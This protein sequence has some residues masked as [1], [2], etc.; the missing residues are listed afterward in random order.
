MLR[1]RTLLTPSLAP[2]AACALAA[3]A[4]ALA[5]AACGGSLHPAEE[6]SKATTV[7]APP[8]PSTK[9]LYIY[10]GLPEHGPERADALQIEQGI[11]Y[12]LDRA[13]HRVGGYRVV[14]TS[15]DDSARQA[16]R[17]RHGKAKAATSDGWNP[18]AAA[19]AAEEAAANP[20]TVAYIGDL[21]SG[22]TE[23]SLPILNE[24]GIAQ[25]TPGSGYPG[26]TVGVRGV[27]SSAEPGV[28]YP[29]NKRSMVRLVPNDLVEA[30]A[31]ADWLK[32]GS[33]VACQ[34]VA[35]V[36]FGDR[37]FGDVQEYNA[38]VSALNTDARADHLPFVVP[39]TSPGTDRKH[40]P[41][42]VSSL[43]VHHVNCLV[44]VGSPSR[45]AVDFTNAYHSGYS[46]ALIV[47][48]SGLCNRRWTKPPR[49]VSLKADPV[50]YCTTPVLRLRDYPGGTWLGDH[51]PEAQ[52]RPATAYNYYGYLAAS[53]VIKAISLIG[54]NDNRQQ[55]L[56]NL[57]NS[58]SAS[59]DLGA[60]SYTFDP[61]GDITGK[62]E[63][64][65]GLDKVTDGIPRFSRLLTGS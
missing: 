64:W 1:L 36:T 55:V 29:Q 24:A 3:F 50:L 19:H 9:T 51:F 38:L 7:K 52:H 61:N 58:N 53:L 60:S 62:Q 4:C 21:D 10:S 26:L 47:G 39:S 44:V 34:T 2:A 37:R 57:V 54:P 43:A 5:I 33:P 63:T 48:T 27:T 46:G 35:A 45:A 41:G 22:A 30:A 6:S 32:K 40:Y 15:L 49:G 25:L 20:Q 12:A 56:F 16:R 28:Y 23:I 11:R 65:Y 8:P 14:Y 13:H 42:Y 59:I 17:H 31:L 18:A